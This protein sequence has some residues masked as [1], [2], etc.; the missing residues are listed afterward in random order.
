[1]PFGV[2]DGELAE[3][4]CGDFTGG[5]DDEK[6]AVDEVL[7]SL[8][9]G[10]GIVAVGIAEDIDG[11]EAAGEFGDCREHVIGEDADI[12]ADS[13]ENMEQHSAIE[14]A[15]GVIQHEDGGPGAGDVVEV[16]GRDAEADA[17]FV[18]KTAGDG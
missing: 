16:L 5:E 13:A 1:M 11:N 2:A 18:E 4:E 14:Q 15:S 17:Q 3:L 10:G 8:L 7:E 9:H 12:G 6:P